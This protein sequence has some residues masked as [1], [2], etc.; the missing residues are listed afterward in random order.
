MFTTGPV[1]IKDSKIDT[2][3]L[4][5]LLLDLNEWEQ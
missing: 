4:I 1:N 3:G 2:F 5:N